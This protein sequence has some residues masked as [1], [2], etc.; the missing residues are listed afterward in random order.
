MTDPSRPRLLIL[1]F[2]PIVSDARLLKQVRRFR[3]DYAVTTCGYGDAPEGVVEHVRIPDDAPY[4]DVNAKLLAV[5]QFS[6]AYWRTSAVRAA[7]RALAGR[8]FDAVLTNDLETVP[9]ARR[10][11]PSRIIHADLHEYSP[12]RHEHVADWVRWRQPYYEWLCRAHV[13]RVA[14][15]S[16]VSGG[17]ARQ[18]AEQFGFNPDVVTNAAPYAD[19]AALPTGE[20]LRLVHSGA[21]MADRD[22]MLM[23]D[24]VDLARTDVTLDLFLTPNNPRYVDDLRARASQVEGVT[25]HDPVPYERLVATLNEYDVGVFI[26]PPINFSYRWALPN[27]FFDYVQARLGV[28]VGPSEE[29][30]GPVRAHGIGAVAKAFDAP[31]LAEVIDGLSPEQVT[32][33]KRASDAAAHELSAENVAHVWARA[34]DAIL[35]GRPGGGR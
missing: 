23:I 32:A 33:W 22:L 16:T 28:V 34:V 3:D 2:S 30:A 21:G 5:R 4:N 18:Y 14:S 9:L 1:S 25:V 11:W 26:L 13:S 6:V 7:H 17:L 31:A 24:A 29:M 20:P 27:K 10:H 8:E 35:A 19:L 12:R 15:T